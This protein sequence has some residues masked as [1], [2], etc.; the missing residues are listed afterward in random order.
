MTLL[1]RTRKPNCQILSTTHWL[2]IF[3]CSHSCDL[4]MDFLL[5][6]WSMGWVTEFTQ[7]VVLPSLCTKSDE[8]LG[9]ARHYNSCRGSDLLQMSA[10]TPAANSSYSLL[11][12]QSW[13]WIQYI[14]SPNIAQRYYGW[15]QMEQPCFLYWM[16]YNNRAQEST[17]WEKKS[18]NCLASLYCHQSSFITVPLLLGVIKDLWYF[19]MVC[20]FSAALSMWICV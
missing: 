16:Y 18:L 5:W 7:G 1:K 9:S 20:M 4:T 6:H 17:N 12:M 19:N 15:S 14:T 8:L 10:W 2:Y 3:W 13:N 11:L